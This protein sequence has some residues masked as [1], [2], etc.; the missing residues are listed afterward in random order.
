MIPVRLTLE[1]IYSYQAA[2]TID[3]ERLTAAQLFGIFG[4]VG[5][6]KSTILEAMTLA[7]YGESA[8]LSRADNRST[9]MLNLRSDRLAVDFTFLDRSAHHHRFTVEA[10]RNRT[11]PEEVGSLTRRAYHLDDATGEWIPLDHT[12]GERVLG[13]SYANFRRTTIIP[14]GRFQE[15][16]Q[17][18]PKDRT[19]MMKELFQLERFDLYGRTREL[20]GETASRLTAIESAL[21][22]L[23]EEA[24]SQQQDLAAAQASLRTRR[25]EAAAARENAAARRRRLE[26]Q[27]S[28]SVE[29][30][31]LVRER[32]QLD[33]EAASLTRREER[34]SVLRLLRDAV[35]APWEQRRD[36]RRR[37][38]AAG[39]RLAEA[40]RERSTVAIR[41][42][43]LEASENELTRRLAERPGLEALVAALGLVIERRPLVTDLEE[44]R[45][46]HR[47]G[48][49]RREAL[50]AEGDQLGA[51]ILQL[52]EGLPDQQVLGQLAA[53]VER[54]ERAIAAGRAISAHRRDAFA[55]AELPE[56]TPEA[57][58]RERERLEGEIRNA[59]ERHRRR[60]IREHVAGLAGSLVEESPVPSADRS[61]IR[62]H[63]S[64]MEGTEE[65]AEATPMPLTLSRPSARSPGST[66]SPHGCTLSFSLRRPSRASQSRRSRPDPM[67]PGPLGMSPSVE[68]TPEQTREPTL[69]PAGWRSPKTPQRRGSGSPRRGSATVT[70]SALRV[71]LRRSPPPS[72]LSRVSLPGTRHGSTSGSGRSAPSLSARVPRKD[73]STNGGVPRSAT[74][75][76]RTGWKRRG[77]TSSLSSTG[78]RRTAPEPVRPSP[79]RGKKRRASALWRD[80]RRR[81]LEEAARERSAADRALASALEAVPVQENEVAELLAELPGLPRHEEEIRLARE[82]QGEIER[83]ITTLRQKLVAAGGTIPD[84]TIPGEVQ[85]EVAQLEAVTSAIRKELETVTR[86][87]ATLQKE[88]EDLTERIGAIGSQLDTLTRQIARRDELRGQRETLQA[89]KDNLAT[90]LNLFRGAGFVGYVA[91]VYL[92]QLVAAANG[93]FR[94]LSRNQ[95]ELALSG[96]RDLAVIDHLNGGRRRSVKTLSGGQT[97]QAALCLALA[98]VDSIDGSASG[99]LPAFFFLDEGFGSL[100]GESLREVFDTLKNL[101]RENRIIGIISHVEALQQEIDAHLTIHLDEDRGSRI[102]TV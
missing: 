57:V 28:I 41:R 97:F 84:P 34:V 1:G 20:Q 15:F 3:F 27:E 11:R 8:R 48:A 18:G 70:R 66:V 49:A 87:T 95:L 59:E 46:R 96:D 31:G 75:S 36:A 35:A 89:R 47:E 94:R 101:R 69:S 58:A 93:R 29:L 64:S 44:L 9:N 88:L 19:E 71:G 102:R 45:R 80:E 39:E 61:I 53:T 63:P 72:L 91:Q 4:P 55:A 7:L 79:R 86:E 56:G 21:G 50:A 23:P 67:R 33:G 25:E 32:T 74:P 38:A 14:Q 54:T 82:R 40:S 5:S 92:E 77:R 6:G 98:L 10:K 76:K 85:L 68:P 26:E 51:S 100:D 73:S 17:L 37:E 65:T 24:E 99:D 16:L 43:R 12:D 2:V 13:L 62:G 52:R 90:L 30:E 81:S 22:E 78:S 42:E 60:T 83:G